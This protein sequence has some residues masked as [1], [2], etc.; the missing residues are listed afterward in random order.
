M[1]LLCLYLEQF[2][3]QWKGNWRYCDGNNCV[4]NKQRYQWHY[5]FSVTSNQTNYCLPQYNAVT[6]T[7]T[8]NKMQRYYN[9]GHA[10]VNTQAHAQSHNAHTNDQSRSQR[11]GK[12]NDFKGSFCKLEV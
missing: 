4:I 11:D 7:V 5:F 2:G 10:G 12:S 9:W 3:L 1:I 6:V 8:D